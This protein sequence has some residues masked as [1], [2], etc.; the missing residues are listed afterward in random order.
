[1]KNIQDTYI[2]WR[3]GCFWGWEVGQNAAYSL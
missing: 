3:M 1:M 2:V